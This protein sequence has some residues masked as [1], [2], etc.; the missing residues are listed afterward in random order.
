[1]SVETLTININV[2]NDQ[3]LN[4]LV[5]W[6]ENI[7][8]L[9]EDMLEWDVNCIFFTPEGALSDSFVFLRESDIVSWIGICFYVVYSW[10]SASDNQYAP[11]PRPPLL[12]G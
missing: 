4:N 7:Q 10:M 9:L 3:L 5:V 1:M 2:Y 6:S 12:T 11:A 8:S